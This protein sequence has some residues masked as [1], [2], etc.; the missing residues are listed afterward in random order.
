MKKI[1]GCTNAHLQM[2]DVCS[3]TDKDGCH[4]YLTLSN[5]KLAIMIDLSDDDKLKPDVVVAEPFTTR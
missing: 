2:T 1:V 3:Q 5:T 4:S